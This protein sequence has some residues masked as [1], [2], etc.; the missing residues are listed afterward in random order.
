MTKDCDGFTED[1]WAR[2]KEIGT[3][4]EGLSEIDHPI[5]VERLDIE[6]STEALRFDE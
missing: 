6:L 1:E 2:R 4:R 5:A 3:V